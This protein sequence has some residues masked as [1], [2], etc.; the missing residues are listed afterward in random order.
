[1]PWRALVV[2]GAECSKADTPSPALVH[3]SLL[4]R[5]CESVPLSLPLLG[6][7][8]VEGRPDADQVLQTGRRHRVEPGLI[9]VCGG[10]FSIPRG[11]N[12]LLDLAYDASSP[13]SALLAA[14]PAHD[15]HVLEHWSGIRDECLGVVACARGAGCGVQ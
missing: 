14:L 7:P 9:L 2:L 3:V 1:M 13:A 11:C 6:L 12:G 15:C 5:Q 4:H 10:R 8:A